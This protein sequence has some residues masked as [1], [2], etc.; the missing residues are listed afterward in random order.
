[1]LLSNMPIPFYL[2]MNAKLFVNHKAEMMN[3]FLI[4]YTML[5]QM[6]MHI[7]SIIIFI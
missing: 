5:L 2:Y 1:M 3:F 4:N 6:E 7:F